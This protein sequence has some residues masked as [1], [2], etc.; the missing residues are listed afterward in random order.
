MSLVSS[1]VQKH[2]RYSGSL[3]A[4]KWLS[5]KNAVL[6]G[7]R[8]SYLAVLVFVALVAW[9]EY[10]GT[11][12]ALEYVCNAGRGFLDFNRQCSIIGTS[13]ASRVLEG[14]L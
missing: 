5:L 3:L 8:W 14:G 6:R 1:Q 2:T 12:R 9:G 13:I 11:I 10:A 7:N 4:V